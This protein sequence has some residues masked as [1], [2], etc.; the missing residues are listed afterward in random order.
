[1]DDEG[2][3]GETRGGGNI[4]RKKEEEEYASD[5]SK[6][7]P[8]RFFLRTAAGCVE[9]AKVT[10]SHKSKEGGRLNQKPALAIKA[11]MQRDHLYNWVYI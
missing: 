10:S 8:S 4:L 9:E 3:I 1:M 11:T 7:Q 2:K 5:V 6:K